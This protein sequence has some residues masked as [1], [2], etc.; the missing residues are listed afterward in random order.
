MT[1]VRNGVLARMALTTT[2]ATAVGTVP[3]GTTWLLKAVHLTNTN[4]VATNVTVQMNNA[5]N[6]VFVWLV[7]QT[8]QASSFFAW[9][10]WTAMAPGDVLYVTTAVAPLDVWVAG[11]ALPGELA[12]VP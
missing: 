7:Q 4:A 5:A 12:T 11:A 8:I 2:A 6:T 3:S 9:Y 10:G 1:G